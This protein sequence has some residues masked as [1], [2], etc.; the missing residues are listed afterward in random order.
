M[1]KVGVKRSNSEDNVRKF[2]KATIIKDK[3]G[4]IM[5]RDIKMCQKENLLTPTR[6]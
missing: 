2:D 1:V 3:I 5:G 4:K 6:K